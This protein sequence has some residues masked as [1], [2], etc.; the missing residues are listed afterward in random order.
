MSYSSLYTSI[1]RN[2]W[3]S[4]RFNVPSIFPKLEICNGVIIMWSTFL[5]DLEHLSY[6]S[7]KLVGLLAVPLIQLVRSFLRWLYLCFTMKT[8]LRNWNKINILQIKLTQIIIIIFKLNMLYSSFINWCMVYTIR[9]HGT[10]VKRIISEIILNITFLFMY[11]SSY[12][13]YL[14]LLSTS[15]ILSITS[16]KLFLLITDMQTTAVMLLVYDEVRYNMK[17]TNITSAII[18]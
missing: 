5:A 2:K 14:I 1:C 12:G 16:K 6:S 10:T 8:K 11:V 17:T 7:V 9:T 18:W 4:A 15:E 13:V 3:I